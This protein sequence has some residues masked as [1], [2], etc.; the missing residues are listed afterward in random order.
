M[1]ALAGGKDAD[2][3]FG[4]LVWFGEDGDPILLGDKTDTSFPGSGEPGC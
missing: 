1:Y 4:S 3:T 2:P